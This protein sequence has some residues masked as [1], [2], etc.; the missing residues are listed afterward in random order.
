MIKARFS[1]NFEAKKSRIKRLPKIVLDAIETSAKKRAIEVIEIFHDGIKN[2]ELG[3]EPLRDTTIS[4]K[5]ALGQAQP[6]T[7]LYGWGDDDEEKMT[8]ANMMRITR[9][10]NGRKYWVRPAEGF[11][12]Q[13]QEDIEAGRKPIKLADLFQVHEYGRTIENGFGRGILIR[14]PPR[15]ALHVAYNTLMR[16]LKR[17]ENT[18]MVKEAIVKLVRDGD[19]KAIEEMAKHEGPAGEPWGKWDA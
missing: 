11:H 12:H 17:T 16:K 15:P 9:D 14:I 7:P 13:T 6:E 4:R 18:K 3:L 1:K 5:E 10:A 8:Y 2:D 19:A